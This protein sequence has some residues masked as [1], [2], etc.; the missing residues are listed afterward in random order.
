MYKISRRSSYK[1]SFKFFSCCVVCLSLV[2]VSRVGDCIGL[3]WGCCGLLDTG[4]SHSLSIQFT[5]N[6]K[7]KNSRISI[8]RR[9][10]D[11]QTH[12]EHMRR[13]N[14][15]LFTHGAWK[16]MCMKWMH[17]SPGDTCDMQTGKWATPS[18]ASQ[19]DPKIHLYL[20]ATE[21]SL[22][23]CRILMRFRISVTA[24]R[25][26]AQPFSIPRK[27]KRNQ[28]KKWNEMKCCSCKQP[29]PRLQSLPLHAKRQFKYKVSKCG[30]FSYQ[31]F[32]QLDA[33]LAADEDEDRRE[34]DTAKRLPLFRSLWNESCAAVRVVV[35]YI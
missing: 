11:T 4:D 31:L 28:A 17:P 26:A 33:R 34:R 15:M 21:L 7:K 12:K 22:S 10:R 29:R 3:C 8:R 27:P 20:V 14:W 19:R 5:A 13:L 18:K 1:L 25:R 6:K 30:R 32:I 35:I 9:Y 24:P 16:D 23:R 2:G